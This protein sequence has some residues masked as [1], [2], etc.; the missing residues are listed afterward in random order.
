MPCRALLVAGRIEYLEGAR[1][2]SL[3]LIGVIAAVALALRCEEP[4]L[5]QIKKLI[6]DVIVE[7]IALPAMATGGAV[8]PGGPISSGLGHFSTD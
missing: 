3:S 8:E 4:V 6:P 1:R 7:H 2:L 5:S